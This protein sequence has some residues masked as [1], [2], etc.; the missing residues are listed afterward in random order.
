VLG[1]LARCENL[2]H[3][4]CAV[5]EEYRIS[6]NFVSLENSYITHDKHIASWMCVCVSV[7]HC[8]RAQGDES[9]KPG[10]DEFVHKIAADVNV[11]ESVRC[12]GVFTYDYT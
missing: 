4:T 12:T 8:V 5:P 10:L 2:P 1:G 7:N 9:D 3:D 6:L 11:A